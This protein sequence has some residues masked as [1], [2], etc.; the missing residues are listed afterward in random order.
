MSMNREL[1]IVERIEDGSMLDGTGDGGF[2]VWETRAE[3]QDALDTEEG[4]RPNDGPWQVVRFSRWGLA[5]PDG[6]FLDGGRP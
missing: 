3:A 2:T 4:S 5:L 1:F 6:D